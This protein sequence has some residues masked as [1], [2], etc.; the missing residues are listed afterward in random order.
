MLDHE[1]LD[2]YRLSLDFLALV[3]PLLEQLPRGNAQIS[4]QLRR[5]ALSIP[6]N[7][8]EGNGKPSRPDR[9]RFFAIARG[10]SMECAAV[11]DILKLMEMIGDDDRSRAK[12]MLERIVAMLSKMAR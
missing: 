7:I 8:A 9:R 5:A 11:I 3:F 4:D 12:Q 6:L 2:V 1:K 10:S